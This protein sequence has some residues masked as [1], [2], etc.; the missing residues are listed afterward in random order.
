MYDD[1]TAG[2]PPSIAHAEPATTRELPPDQMRPRETWNSRLG[3]I[4][5]VMGSAVGLGNFLRFPGK[6]A[7]YEG[8][9]FMIPYFIALLLLGIPLAWAEWGLGRYGGAR[10]FNSAA[11]I[12]RTVWKNRIAPYFGILGVLIPICV[13]FYYVFVEGWCLAY[14]WF[15][16]SGKFR[17]QGFLDNPAE[18]GNFFN[19]F[20]GANSDGF[21]VQGGAESVSVFGIN[22]AVLFLLVCFILNFALVYRGL[23]KGI[24]L[25]CLWAMPILVLCALVVLIRVLTLPNIET[26]LGFMWNLRTTPEKGLFESLM[27]PQMWLEATGQIFFSLSVGFGIVLCYASYLRRNDDVALSSLTSASGNEFCEV[28]LGGMIT[29]PA[30]FIFLGAT[31]IGG[32]FGLGFV[33]LPQVFALMPGGQIVGALFFFLLFLAAITSSLSMLQP[34]IAL[35]EEGLGLNRKGSV[36]ILGMLTLVGSMFVVYFSQGLVALDTIDFWVGT[37]CIFVLATFQTI[38]FGW[39]L[40]VDRGMDEINRGSAIRIPRFIGFMLKYVCPTYLLIIFGMWLYQAAT[41]TSGNYFV[42]LKESWVAKLSVGL[43]ILVAVFF[44]LLI[45]IAVKRWRTTGQLDRIDAEGGPPTR[46]F[47]VVQT[48]VVTYEERP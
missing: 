28:A 34:A 14:A 16:L 17:E 20:T 25:F 11:G 48:T 10:G 19:A 18:Y 31:A 13:Y 7:Q 37:F 33:T 44:G 29:V 26:G 35:L 23:Q 32:T 36:A 42:T 43:V 24:E 2:A 27:N 41:A 22:A 40:G 45:N 3:V 12:Y 46:A 4:M 5:A 38:L 30:A 1:D 21:L 6:A 9:A 39:G 47:A 15:M 8:G